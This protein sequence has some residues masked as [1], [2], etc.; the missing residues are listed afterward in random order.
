[1]HVYIS[2]KSSFLL[3]KNNEKVLFAFKKNWTV[4]IMQIINVLCALIYT[5]HKIVINKNNVFELYQTK[6]ILFIPITYSYKL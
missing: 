3:A 1:M 4:T 6:N 2:E 5:L